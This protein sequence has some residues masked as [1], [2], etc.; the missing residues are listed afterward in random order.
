ML[1]DSFLPA[2][3]WPPQ[4]QEQHFQM[5]QL[6]QFLLAHPLLSMLWLFVALLLANNLLRSKF[7]KIG[8]LNPQEVTLLMNRH[9]ATL[10]DIRPAA[11]FNKGH[12][13]GAINLPNSK[14]A[15]TKTQLEK[16]RANPLILVCVSGLQAHAACKQLTKD[17]FSQLNLLDGGMN[18]WV[19]ANLPQERS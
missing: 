14:L 11:E 18:A 12:I 1:G 10:V 19:S 17:G 7:G 9:N 2:I 8:H 16:Y 3:Q 15:D 6:T 4:I 5:A 13:L